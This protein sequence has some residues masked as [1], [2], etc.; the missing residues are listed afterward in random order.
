MEKSAVC[1]WE[2]RRCKREFDF[3]LF[4]VGIE[5]E[6]CCKSPPSPSTLDHFDA[7]RDGSILCTTIDEK[8]V[9]YVLRK[10]SM[11]YFKTKVFRHEIHEEMRR[12]FDSC[13]I[14]A[15]PYVAP[16]SSSCGV[17][18]H[19]SHDKVTKTHFPFFDVFFS[20]YWRRTLYKDLKKAFPLRENNRFTEPNPG[21]FMDT[22]NA[23]TMR[24]VPS[25]YRQLNL[26]PS[27]EKGETLWHFEFRGLGDFHGLGTDS[28]ESTKTID[29]FIVALADAYLAGV[30]A[31]INEQETDN[32]KTLDDD[33]W[34]EQYEHALDQDVTTLTSPGER[35]ARISDIDFMRS[36]AEQ[37][38]VT[39]SSITLS[40]SVDS[41]L[42][43][44][45][46]DLIWFKQYQ[47]AKRD[48]RRSKKT[49]PSDLDNWLDI[50]PLK[51]AESLRFDHTSL[52]SLPKEIGE[53][54]KLQHLSFVFCLHLQSLPESIG[55]LTSLQS[56]NLS[57]C[58][59]LK[60]LP[61]SIG[62]LTSLTELNLGGCWHLD[63][64]PESIGQCKSLTT[65]NL[66][67]CTSLDS[68]PNSIGKLTNLKGLYMF[69]MYSLGSL[70]YSIGQLKSL[71]KL[72]LSECQKLDSLPNSI[73]DLTS[74]T[75][76]WLVGCKNLTSLPKR[77]GK[78]KSLTDLS[79]RGCERLT[80]L[81]D[82]IGQCTSLTNLNLDDCE[83]LKSLPKS[84]GQLTN[85]Q[86]LEC[87]NCQS[88]V[89]L[90]DS[91][92]K[93]KSLTT[94]SLTYC[95]ELKSLPKTIGHLTSLTDLKLTACWNLQS[96]PESIW[97]LPNLKSL[98]FEDT[99][100]AEQMPEALKLKLKKKF[101]LWW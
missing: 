93:L 55:N 24:H 36:Y 14:C 75:K 78:L 16:H 26:L 88:L 44:I 101:D 19:L 46:Y 28:E 47:K 74:L 10:D 70:P 58:R 52:T 1:I 56:L 68:L 38:H 89:S 9:E 64:L 100:A 42:N 2:D 92:G 95:G 99:P 66:Y 34:N 98:S 30:R 83:N 59:I 33:F 79:L 3:K 18:V 61:N 8:P 72:M 84:I 43:D 5:V 6:T 67:K 73:G 62:G 29:D 91:I 65:L 97:K 20:E 81:P 45:K 80:S 57:N 11:K 85:L 39:S 35:Y 41:K 27:M 40:P 15:K 4:N 54:K 25:K 23:H 86:T 17:H 77:I 21:F 82:S 96:L 71:T 51:D 90:P 12:I 94:L 53:L 7:T 63:S 37:K 49:R 22:F 50:K 48:L 87:H 60:S 13:A 76:L 31:Y 69:N 32:F